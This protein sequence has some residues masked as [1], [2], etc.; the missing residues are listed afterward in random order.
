LFEHITEKLKGFTAG[1]TKEC[2]KM[3]GDP[4]CDY[5]LMGLGSMPLQQMTPY[6]DLEFAILTANDKYRASDDPKVRNYFTNLSHLLHFKVINLGET[7]IPAS[8]FKK[9]NDGFSLHLEHLVKRGFNFDLG[10]KT[11]LSHLAI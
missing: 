11:V 7:V 6:S 9:Y 5:T 2:E 3:L 10:G 8:K 4:P 1:L